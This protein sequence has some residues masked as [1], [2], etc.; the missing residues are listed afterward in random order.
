[1]SRELIASTFSSFLPVVLLALTALAAWLASLIARH[2]R[3]KRYSAAVTLLAYGAAGVVADITQHTVEALKDPTKPGKWDAVAGAAARLRAIELLRSLYPLAVDFVLRV[4]RD[5][6]KVDELLGTLVERAVVDLKSQ[7]G[8]ASGA[9]LE[10]TRRDDTTAPR[11]SLVPSAIPPR[12]NGQRGSASFGAMVYLLAVVFIGVGGAVCVLSTPGCGP[13]R[14]A[15]M[16]A[17]SGVPD[18]SNCTPETWRCHGTT[19]EVCSSSGRWWPSLPRRED[20]SPRT[21]LDGCSIDG[22]GVAG[23]GD[24]DGGTPR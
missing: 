8:G 10:L 13:A 19:P 5:P 24:A 12:D 2:I 1:M 20:G 11:A 16:R 21:C 7:S 6:K 9:A 22:N 3:D 15:V 4:L 18:P 17:A 14:E 23:C